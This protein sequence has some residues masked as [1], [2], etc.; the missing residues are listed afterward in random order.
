MFGVVLSAVVCGLVPYLVIRALWCHFNPKR[1][2]L[3]GKHVLVR[4]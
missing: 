3:Q 2:H 4:P 1:Q